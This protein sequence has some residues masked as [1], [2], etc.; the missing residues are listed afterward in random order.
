MGNCRPCSCW[1]R[2]GL[3]GLIQTPRE[4]EE[5]LEAVVRTA[6]GEHHRRRTGLLAALVED[7]VGAVIVND[8]Q[9]R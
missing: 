9:G 4:Q 5:G 3:G 8:M 1:A 7:A 6:L 2:A